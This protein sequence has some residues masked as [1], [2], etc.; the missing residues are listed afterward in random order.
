MS[1][2]YANCAV[3]L[4][5]V[6]AGP[7]A[8]MC[9]G[10]MCLGLPLLF[11]SDA[12]PAVAPAP[13]GRDFEPIV[14]LQLPGDLEEAQEAVP[15]ASEQAKECL[16]VWRQLIADGRFDLAPVVA[17]K[18]LALD[19]NNREARQAVA[20]SK[21]LRSEPGACCTPVATQTRPV[22]VKSDN[23]RIVDS[24]LSYMM[25]HG[26]LGDGPNGEC[27]IS[28]CPAGG[29]SVSGSSVSKVSQAA[30]TT[31]PCACKAKCG[32]E[33]STAAVT[34]PPTITQPRALM[35][36]AGV[37]CDAGLATCAGATCQTLSTTKRVTIKSGAWQLECDR[38]ASLNEQ[39]M[40]LDGNV[41]MTMRTRDVSVQAGRVHVNFVDGNIRI[42][43]K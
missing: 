34:V 10:T 17:A 27:P 21:V 36:G 25:P 42:E 1:R 4:L 26:L 2:I 15:A 33:N 31:T 18:A 3:I 29:S 22:V 32:S 37:N 19:P 8:A 30:A 5:L 16:K 38:V 43:G 40:I 12:P 20:V 11:G 28:G 39:E 35:F 41:T 14:D 24:V 6:L 9:P 23:D 13:T 7:A